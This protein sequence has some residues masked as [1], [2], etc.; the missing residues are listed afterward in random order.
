MTAFNRKRYKPPP[1]WTGLAINSLDLW[2]N[3]TEWC[4]VCCRQINYF[5]SQTNIFRPKQAFLAIKKKMSSPNPHSACYALLVLESVV[6]NCGS[7]VHE[8]VFTRENCEMF[9]HF[10]EQTP[11]ENVRQKMLELVQTWAYAF[12]SSEKYQSIKVS[13]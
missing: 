11:H 7:P 5:I 8:E 6:K 9:S 13:L 10:L 1:P 12:R 3:S 4:Y 2:C